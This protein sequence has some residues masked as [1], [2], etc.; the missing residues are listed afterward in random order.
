MGTMQTSSAN[1]AAKKNEIP[2]SMIRTTGETPEKT[3]IK[4]ADIDTL[5]TNEHQSMIAA[6]YRAKYSDADQSV[7]KTEWPQFIGNHFMLYVL[8]ETLAE[9]RKA[10]FSANKKLL[11]NA[12][13]STMSRYTPTNPGATLT[14][15]QV[16]FNKTVEMELF[17]LASKLEDESNR[18]DLLKD[19]AKLLKLGTR[20]GKDTDAARLAFNYAAAKLDVIAG[21]IW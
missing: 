18:V 1:G 10:V 14:D 19:Y 15:L 13:V 3:S 6:K 5:F 8:A 4:L 16:T 11:L 2:L 17:G 7:H 21:T 9:A 12:L 20:C